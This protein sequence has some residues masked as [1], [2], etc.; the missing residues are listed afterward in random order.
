MYREI[1][2]QLCEEDAELAS[3]YAAM[4][5]RIRAS[6]GAAEANVHRQWQP[7]DAKVVQAWTSGRYSEEGETWEL[8][9][10]RVVGSFEKISQLPDAW[11]VAIF[12]SATPIGIW[13]ALTMDIFDQRSI[14][15]AGVIHNSAYSVFRFLDHN[16]RLFSFNATP[17]LVD[18][19]LRTHR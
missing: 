13:T 1:A 7:C 4:K 17:H 6:A 14:R 10:R 3:E 11:H 8:F 16:L 18:P 15:L 19:A 2:P 9:L 5:D 12:T